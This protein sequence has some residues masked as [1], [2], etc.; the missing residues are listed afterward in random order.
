M[1]FVPLLLMYIYLLALNPKRPPS[2]C[3]GASWFHVLVLSWRW[4]PYEELLSAV[5]V[6]AQTSVWSV[7]YTKSSPMSQPM[8]VLMKLG[9]GNGV[10][11]I[12]K[13]VEERKYY[14]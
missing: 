5:V 11:H 9:L 10:S 12:Y 13:L 7:L 6:A 4:L 1:G 8:K 14:S 2:K 3:P